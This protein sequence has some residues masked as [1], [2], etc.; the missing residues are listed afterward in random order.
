MMSVM[1]TKSGTFFGRKIGSLRQ[2]DVGPVPWNGTGR[3]ERAELELERH[4][5]A[6]LREHRSAGRA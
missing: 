4:F 1:Q 5:V 3:R 6:A 2:D